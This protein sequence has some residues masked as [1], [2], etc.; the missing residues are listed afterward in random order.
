M[1][2]LK[3]ADVGYNLGNIQIS[4]TNANTV[5]SSSILKVICDS[6]IFL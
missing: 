2:P 1:G 3:F 6:P 4:T 5:T